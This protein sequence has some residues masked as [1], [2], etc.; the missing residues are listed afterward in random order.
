MSRLVP[1]RLVTFGSV[2]GT[3]RHDELEIVTLKKVFS[4][5]GHPAHPVAR[6]LG[7]SLRG[8]DVVHTHHMRSAASRISALLSLGSSKT[9]VTTDHGLGGGGWAGLLPKMFDGFLTVSEFS[10]RTLGAPRDKT[11][12][13]YG[14]CDIDRFRSDGHERRDGILYVGRVTPH[15]GID[16]LLRALPRGAR[17]TIAGTAGHDA[18]R[19]ESGYGQLLH[20]LAAGKDV[21]FAGRVDEEALPELYRR[22]QVFVLPSVDVTCY[23]KSI[24][25]SELLGL[26][27]LEAMA[28]GTPV[29]A[30]RIG[31]LPEVVV[32]GV[33]GY[34]VEP[35]DE[36]GLRAA[37]E[38]LLGDRKKALAMGRAGRELVADSFTWDRCARRCID[39]YGAAA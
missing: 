17:L 30:S 24:A 36:D 35:R 31:G 38:E 39:A 27:L 2:A 1:T 15:K 21:G 7:A 23:G 33:T 20:D 8:S 19:A 12:V 34:L 11:H 10:A 9:L 16:R 26:S 5:K 28:S 13:V 14:G 18:G 37:I 4:F 3:R 25:I 32:D 29:V 22:S 6:G